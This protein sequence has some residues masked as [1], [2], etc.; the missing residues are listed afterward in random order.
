MSDSAESLGH[1]TIAT[2]YFDGLSKLVP[3]GSVR[4]EKSAWTWR[5]ESSG[6]LPRIEPVLTKAEAWIELMKV[7]RSRFIE[8]ASSKIE[9]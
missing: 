3:N 2:D 6:Q 7:S 8:A 1:P 4:R 5:V 9:G